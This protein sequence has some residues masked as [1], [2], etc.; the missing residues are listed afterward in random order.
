MA[1][2]QIPK[3]NGTSSLLRTVLTVGGLFTPPEAHVPHRRLSSVWWTPA[4]PRCSALRC[5]RCLH[6]K[7]PRFLPG[8]QASGPCRT[9]AGAYGHPCSSI[10]RPLLKITSWL[11]GGRGSRSRTPR[12]GARGAGV[13]LDVWRVATTS[14][15]LRRQRSGRGVQ[16]SP[17]Y[18]RNTSL[19]EAPVALIVPLCA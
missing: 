3:R 17:I 6:N 13:G 12:C 14:R 1:T 5:R 4:M 15:I 2:V 11:R 16:P 8:V 9:V 18:A 10:L 19:P 7:S